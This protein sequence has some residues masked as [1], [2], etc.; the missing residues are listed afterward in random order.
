MWAFLP[1]NLPSLLLTLCF[2]LLAG[3]HMACPNILDKTA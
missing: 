2:V 1:A 3:T